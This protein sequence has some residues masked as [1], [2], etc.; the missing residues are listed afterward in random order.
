MKQNC[1][2]A[3]QFGRP[4]QLV[5][6]IYMLSIIHHQPQESGRPVGHLPPLLH[7]SPSYADTGIHFNLISSGHKCWDHP[8][9]FSQNFE[10][11]VY[12]YRAISLPAYKTTRYWV[13]VNQRSIFL[14]L[15]LPWS[16]C[17]SFKPQ[18]STYQLTGM[19][20]SL[21]N[22]IKSQIL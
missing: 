12:T 8:R 7:P 15:L 18:I 6:K 14:S 11:E 3:L 5:L 1:P 17:D 21:H 13:E 2:R 16:T 4:S 9:S 22:P 20:N 19:L 10:Q